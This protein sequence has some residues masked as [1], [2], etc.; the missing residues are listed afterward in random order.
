MKP[1]SW[2]RSPRYAPA[3]TIS[4]KH[5]TTG[6]RIKPSSPQ[7]KT[8]SLPVSST[9]LQV[10]SALTASF[11]SV[12]ANRCI[13]F[14]NFPATTGSFPSSFAS[15]TTSMRVSNAPTTSVPTTS[16]DCKPPSP[17]AKPSTT[18]SSTS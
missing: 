16:P 18:S 9:E 13:Y 8:T 6:Q 17:S 11:T 3:S 1:G 14:K 4:T 15:S 12:P 2:H 5:S 7:P 10:T